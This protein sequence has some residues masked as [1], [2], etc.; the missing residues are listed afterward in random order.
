MQPVESE[1]CGRHRDGRNCNQWGMSDTFCF[2]F[3]SISDW[4]SFFK[5]W[6]IFHLPSTRKR[7]NFYQPYLQ[8]VHS[9]VLFWG[10]VQDVLP[11]VLAH[12]NFPPHLNSYSTREWTRLHFWKCPRNF[13]EDYTDGF[14]LSIRENMSCKMSLDCRKMNFFRFWVMV[15]KPTGNDRFQSFHFFILNKLDHLKCVPF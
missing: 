10:A 13:P 6:F 8:N 9:L 4:I 1:T 14:T 3:P 11:S 15:K 12:F 2:I 7:Y 5:F